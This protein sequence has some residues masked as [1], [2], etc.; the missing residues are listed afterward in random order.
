MVVLAL[1][2]CY[3]HRRRRR[4]LYR[5]SKSDGC[6]RSGHGLASLFLLCSL[7]TVVRGR[8]IAVR[9]TPFQIPLPTKQASPPSC[10][11]IGVGSLCYSVCH[12]HSSSI[13]WCSLFL[14]SLSCTCA[15]CYPFRSSSLCVC[16]IFRFLTPPGAHASLVFS[17][18]PAHSPSIH[19][20]CLCVYACACAQ[21]EHRQQRRTRGRSHRRRCSR[22]RSSG[23]PRP[24]DSRSRYDIATAAVAP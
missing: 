21:L 12:L 15:S 22:S 16:V 9:K 20:A 11:S 5:R 17:L 1:V 2:T 3:A 14:S 4:C 13:P 10:V 8:R 24:V 18:S 7:S 23:R 19:I 6:P